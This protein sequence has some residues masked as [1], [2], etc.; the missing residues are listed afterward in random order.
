MESKLKKERIRKVI[1]RLIE[2]E[3]SKDI[4]FILTDESLKILEIILRIKPYSKKNCSQQE[5]K[6]VKKISAKGFK[7]KNKTSANN[8]F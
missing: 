6:E 7:K 4:D 2:I 3:N 1:E 5:E 8:K